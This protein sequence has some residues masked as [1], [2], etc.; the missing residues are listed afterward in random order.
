MLRLA[1]ALSFALAACTTPDG[2]GPGD[3]AVETAAPR[4]A[5]APVP[6]PDTFEEETVLMAGRVVVIGPEGLREHAAIMQDSAHHRYE[7]KTT[8]D[9]LLRRTTLREGIAYLAPIRCR[10]DG[11]QI[12]AERELVVL[13]KPGNV[14]LTIQADGDVYWRSTGTGEERRSESL[15][16]RGD[17]K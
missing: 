14:P 1:L 9:G 15:I 12:F 8:A 16:L 3:P 4:P 13:E 2:D 5:A 17:P 10:L 11:M 7:E 6:W